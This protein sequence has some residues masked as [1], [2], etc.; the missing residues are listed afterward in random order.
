[1]R[2]N[3]L[4][5][6]F[7]LFAT[8]SLGSCTG[9]DL[10][11]PGGGGGGSS[12]ALTPSPKVW[13]GQKRGKLTY[14]LLVYSF[15]DSNG[16]GIGD[17][18][19]ITQKLDYINDLGISAL[20][21]SPIH[22]CM[23]Y[24]GYD[25]TDYAAVNPDFGTMADF[26]ELVDQAHSRDIKIYLDYVINHTGREHSWFQ[27]AITS[28]ENQY[29][30]F[31][32]ISENP[33]ADIAAG[34]IPMINSQGAA[35]YADNEWFVAN[36][37]VTKNYLFTLDWS[38][39]NAPTVTITESTTVDG[40]NPDV[41]TEGA[42][43]LYFGK[44]KLKKFYAQADGIYTL[45]LDFSSDW[46]FL[47]RTSNAAEWVVG[48]KYGTKSTTDRLVIGEPFKLETDKSNNDNV[49][50]IVM[51]GSIMF[52]SNFYTD[53]FADLNYGAAADAHNSPAFKAIVDDAKVWINAGVD[54]LRLDAVKHIYRN[55]DSDEN[56]QFLKQFYDKI[57]EYYK[58]KNSGEVY[59]VG[60]VLSGADQV[61]PYYKGLP[62]LFEFSFWFKLE[63]AINNN[64][65]CFILKDLDEFEAKYSAQREDYMIAT[66][67]S[68]HDENRTRST[69]GKSIQKS[70]LAA[71]ILLTSRGEPYIYYGEEL[72]YYG[73]KEAGDE[74]VRT[75]MAWGDNS[76]TTTYTDKID[77]EMLSDVGDTDSQRSDANSMLNLYL[78]FSQLRNNYDALAMGKMSQH[79]VYNQNNTEFKSIAAWYMTY[80]DEKLLVI[81]NVSPLATVIKLKDITKSIVGVNGNIIAIDQTQGNMS[82][83]MGA[84]STII[85]EL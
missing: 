7:A 14:Q 18:K 77:A 52:H 32:S 75:P 64:T 30:D 80:G 67:L 25:A 40:D 61:A 74:Y 79:E 66:K 41:S 83:E 71:A 60:E 9:D 44:D 3:L 82:L 16:D 76:S 6:I 11:R 73:T 84:Y 81:H 70:K 20:W 43:Y 26:E 53:W 38:D 69:L 48:T 56:P 85:F 34:K 49:K 29:R 21:L 62:A 51:P 39:A 2:I 1:M 8:L 13:D 47:V 58:S 28:E 27:S 5:Y 23:S 78:Q 50:N 12:S 72:G 33:A 46:G 45:N 10:K 54:G 35:G 4:I 65:G 31:Y 55:S 68:N 59:M 57:N 63:W 22:P 15:A 42:K 19:G 17:F 24:H 36:N 37:T